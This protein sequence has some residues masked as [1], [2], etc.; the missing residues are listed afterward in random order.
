MTNTFELEATV[1]TEQGKLP[2]RRLRV[3]GL[4][5]GVLYG[6]KEKPVSIQFSHR[7]FHKGLE[8]GN[9]FSR[10]LTLNLDGKKEQVILKALQRHPYK[11]L[12]THADFLRVKSDEAISMTVPLHFTGANLAPGI[13]AGGVILYHLRKIDIRCLP[14][15]L[16]ESI[17]V[18]LSKL[19]L[20]QNIHLFDLTLPEQ[21]ELTADRKN[22]EQNL[23][24]VSIQE[25][26]AEEEAKP[27]TEISEEKE[28]KAPEKVKE[29]P[30]TEKEKKGK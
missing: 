14:S 30:A 8:S 27:I 4:T 10:I 24:V 28:E 9:V 6:T 7:E 11:K 18:D 21:V 15:H 20:N 22:T 25:T 1:R 13:K 5:P 2:N 3:S 26:R 19:E 23:P 16:P 12:I 17:T 29:T